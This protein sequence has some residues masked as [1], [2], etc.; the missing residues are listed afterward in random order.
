MANRIAKY[1]VWIAALF[2]VSCSISQKTSKDSGMQYPVVKTAKD[3]DKLNQYDTVIVEGKLKYFK[4]SFSI[5]GGGSQFF[6]FEIRLKHGGELPLS[7]TD[8]IKEEFLNKKVKIVGIYE[9]EGILRPGECCQ[10][11]SLRRIQKIL[12][13]EK[14]K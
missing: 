12:S 8:I 4:P 13:V 3:L 9:C 1:Y 5:K 6:S 11:I 10:D 14:L 2:I 7:K